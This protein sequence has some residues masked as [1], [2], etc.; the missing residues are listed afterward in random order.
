MK[1][2]ALRLLRAALF[3]FTALQQVAIVFAD[4][5]NQQQQQKVKSYLCK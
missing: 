2:A 1:A 3:I 4:E 5:Q